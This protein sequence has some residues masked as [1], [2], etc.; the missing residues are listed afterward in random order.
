MWGTRNSRNKTSNCAKKLIFFLI[1]PDNCRRTT[2]DKHI[3]FVLVT[4]SLITRIFSLSVF[5][6]EE[7]IEISSNFLQNLCQFIA[8]YIDYSIKIL[9]ILKSVEIIDCCRSVVG[10]NVEMRIRKW[11]AFSFQVWAI[12]IQTNW[13]L[14]FQ[15]A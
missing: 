1:E 6:D 7:L 11:N 14:S 3:S 12:R 4:D 15:I 10:L 9:I 13:I 8:W 2:I 5:T